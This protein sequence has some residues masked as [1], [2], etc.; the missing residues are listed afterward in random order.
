MKIPLEWLKEY[1]TIRVSPKVLAHRL[2]MAGLEVVGFLEVDGERVFD[3]E[4]TPNRSDCLS[5][6]GVAREVAAITGQ[7]LKT[8]LS[9]GAR[10]KGQGVRRSLTFPRPPSAAPRPVI[11]IEDHEGCQRY[12]GRLIAGVTVKPSPEWMQRRLIACGVRPINNVVDVTNYVLLE[13]GQP[14]HAFDY[15]RLSEATIRIRRAF[16]DESITTLD[17]VERKL[18]NQTLVIA[19]AKQAVAVAG[20]MGG[21]GTELTAQTRNVLLESA[22]FDPI[23]IRRTAKALGLSTES[24]YRFERGVDPVGVETASQRAS[25]LIVSVSCGCEVACCDAGTKPK[26]RT[27]ITLESDRMNRWLGTT[28]STAN[29]RS[30]LA[31]LSCHVASSGSGTTLQVAVP[32]FR[33][34]LTTAVD[35]YEELARLMGY[36]RIP[37]ALPS[38][39][40]TQTHPGSAFLGFHTRIESLRDFCVS[41]GLIE[42]IHWALIS[43]EDLT[44]CGFKA[45]QAVTLANALS[46]DQA[47]LRPSLVMGLLQSVRRNLFQQAAGVGLFELGSVMQARPSP[48]EKQRLGIALCGWWTLD[49]QTKEPC[50]FFRLKGMLWSI[51]EHWGAGQLQMRPAVCPWLDS[52]Q[53]AELFLAGTSM[54]MAGQVARSV[55]QALDV[56]EPVWIAELD[57]ASL[58]SSGQKLPKITPP[59]SFPPI[60]RDLSILVE[61]RWDCASLERAI[62]EAAGA[63][64]RRLELIDRYSGKQ[65]P[66]GKYSLTFSLEYRD[67]EKTLTAQEVEAVHQRIVQHLASH[68]AAQ[69]R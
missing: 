4:V 63:I 59:S 44:R 3:I 9:P 50:D 28:V 66:E 6:I 7:R 65:T 58:L 14:L 52:A 53:T 26:A 13:Y 10:G 48:M 60:K 42:T 33:R 61:Q 51:V 69:Q 45:E 5:I 47:Y 67:P 62:R 31:Q 38:A 23:L 1:V 16:A 17:N 12:I 25:A 2:T 27:T 37:S 57:V 36:D 35:L 8:T 34:D 54:G 39:T 49:W 21:L 22:W 43:K 40:L 19:D 56:D 20:I 64:L 46:Q 41:L 30:M 32:S 29:V 18:Q 15:D 24:S 55:L 68:F 11:H